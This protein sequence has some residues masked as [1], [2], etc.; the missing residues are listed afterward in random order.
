MSDYGR[1]V[2]PCRPGYGASCALCCGS[3]NYNLGSEE[4]EALFIRRY[5][6]GPRPPYKHPYSVSSGKLYADAMQCPHVGLS[7]DDEI[8]CIIYSEPDKKGEVLSFFNGTCRNFFCPAWDILTDREI[9]FAARLMR[10]WYFYS[11]LINDIESLQELCSSYSSPEDIPEDAVEELK[12][13]ILE[14]FIAEDGK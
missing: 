10:D 7:P 13:E 6:E 4:I 11:L 1:G 2:N 3:H 9:T 5:A 8:C 14:K 12:D